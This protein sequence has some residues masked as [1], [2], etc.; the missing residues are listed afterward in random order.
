MP[1][2]GKDKRSDK[3]AGLGKW[4]GETVSETSVERW[5]HGY[6]SIYSA[7]SRDTWSCR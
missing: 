1:W 7:D 4:E 5:L 6:R 2:G 3:E